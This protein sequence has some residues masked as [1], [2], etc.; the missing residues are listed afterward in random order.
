MKKNFFVKSLFTSI[1]NG[2]NNNN[3]IVSL[4]RSNKLLFLLVNFLYQNG[5]IFGYQITNKKIQLELKYKL[6]GFPFV[7]FYNN[8]KVL[9]YSYYYKLKKLKRNFR[10]SHCLILTTS[11]GILPGNLAVSFKIGGILLFKIN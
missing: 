3:K 5:Y 6:N 1:I 4:K 7:Y 11:L 9:N 2:Y 10:F 8:F